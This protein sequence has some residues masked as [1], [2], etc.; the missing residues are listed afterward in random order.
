[1][2]NKFLSMTSFF[3]LSLA[4]NAGATETGPSF[5]GAE[6]KP[7]G[8][9]NESI[10]QLQIRFPSGV[11]KKAATSPFTVK[12]NP[13]AEGF[14]SWADNETLWTYNFKAKDRSSSNLLAGGTKCSIQQI[15]EV[16]TSDQKVWKKGALNY[17]VTVMGPKVVAVHVAHGF[18]QTLR[19]KEPLMLLVFNGPVDKQSLYGNGSS[20]LSYTSSN[21][22]TEKLS[23]LPVPQDQLEKLFGEFKNQRYFDPEFKDSNWALATVKQNLIPGAQMKL[24]VQNQVSGAN[25]DVKMTEK[26]TQDFSVRSQFQAEIL[27]S[28]QSAKSGTCMPNSAIGVNLNGRVKWTD[29]RKAYIEYIPYQSKDRKTVQSFAEMSGNQEIG[30][31]DSIVDFLA[32]YFPYL[33]KYSDTVVDS[34]TFNVKI[35]P[36]T[37]AKVVLP[38][39]LIDIDGRRLA[40]ALTTFHIKIGSMEEWINTPNSLAIYERNTPQLAIPVGIV[41]LHQK[42]SIRKSGADSNEWI[43]VQD[44]PTMV[45]LI[46]SYEMVSTYRQT[47]DYVSPLEELK[48]ANNSQTQVMKGTKNRPEVLQFPLAKK[49]KAPQ[50]GLYALEISSP[51]LEQENSNEEYGNYL[52]PSHVLAQVTDLSVHMKKGSKQTLLWITRL[53]NAA[54]VAHADISIY[55]CLGE[56]VHTATTDTQGLVTVTNQE[57]AKDCH[58]QQNEYTSYSQK[59]EFFVHAKQGEDSLLAHSSWV[60]PDSYALGAPGVEWFYSKLEEDANYYHSIIGVNLVKPGQEVPVQL[61]AKR[62]EARGFSTVAPAELPTTARVSF[63]YDDET[64]FDFPLQ[65]NNGKAEF[66]WKVPSDNS[67]KLG[68][69]SIMLVD[70]NKDQR[71]ISTGGSIEVAEFKIPLMTGL[72]SLPNENLVQPNAIPVNAVIRYANGVGAKKLAADI[73]YYFEPTTIESKDFPGYTFGNGALQLLDDGSRPENSKLPNSD[74]P[75]T[76]TDLSTGTDGTL[77]LDIAKQAALEQGTIAEALKATDRPQKM[78]VRV[79][80]QDQMG[81]FQTLSRS[82]DIYNSNLYLGTKLRAGSREEARLL[83]AAINAEKKNMTNL[84]DINLKIERIETRVIG[85]ELYGGIIKNTLERQ[86]KPVRWTN[87]CRLENNVVNCSIGALK[88]GNYAFQVSSK[89]TQQIAHL[90]FKVD[91]S[92][93]VFGPREYYQ[94][95]DEQESKT[96][97]L[98]LNKE[99]YRNGEKAIVSFPPPFKSCQ[100]LVTLERNDVMQGF[101][102]ADGCSKGRVEIPVDSSLAPNAFVSVYAVAGRVDT[103]GVKVG[104]QDL[105]R[106]TYRLGFANIKVDWQ[107]F[108]SQVKVTLNKDT[109][110]PK[111]MVDVQAS[112][113]A[114]TGALTEGTVT[115][116]VLEEKILELKENNTYQILDALMQLR[117]HNVATVTSLERIETIASSPNPDRAEGGR[118]G[119]D[120]GGDGGNNAEFKRKLFDALVA[121]KTNVP[122]VNGVAKFSFKTN[123]S[124]TRFKVIA[125]AMDANNKFGTG[126]AGY[127]SAQDVQSY[128]NIP[129]VAYSGDE[130]PLKVTVQNNSSNDANYRA[131]ITITMKDSHGNIIGTK[132]LQKTA[133]IGASSS[134]AIDAGSFEINEDAAKIEYTIRIYDENGKLVDVLEPEAQ[135]VLPTVPLSIQRSYLVQMEQESWQKKVVKPEGALKDKGELQIVVS[136]S[137]VTGALEQIKAKIKQ[138]PFADFFIEARL[139]KALLLGSEKNVGD[140]KTV[141][142]VMMGSVDPN[143]F[144]KYFPG[145]TKGDAYLTAQLINALE[146]RPWA[147]AQMPKALNS[148]LNQAVNLVLSKKADPNYVGKTPMDWARLQMLMVRSALVLGNKDLEALAKVVAQQIHATAVKDEKPFGKA[149][150]EWSTV[151]LVNLWLTQVKTAPETALQSE[152]Y[153]LLTQPSRLVYAGNGAQF[154]GTPSFFIRYTDEIIETAQ[155]L[156]GHASVNG[157]KDLARA[158][159]IGLVNANIK[160]CWYNDAT[161][162]NLALG[163]EAFAN[164]YEMATVSG[165]GQIAVSQSNDR[166]EINW[167][168]TNKSTLKTAWKENESV[169]DVQHRGQGLPWVGVQALAAVPLNAPLAQGVSVEKTLRNLNRE[170]GY[171]AGDVIEVEL[172][173]NAAARLSH[174]ALRDPIPAGSNILSEAYGDY[175]SG[176]KRYSGYWLYFSSIPAG[177]SKVKYQFQLNNPGTF[178]MAP[179]RV[180]GIY[181]PSVFA[182]IPNTALTVK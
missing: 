128:S 6:P 34:I 2:K 58:P 166:T 86:L 141:F 59:D 102:T 89:S 161:L 43:P 169:I 113:Q 37:Q 181:M 103:G 92:G 19:E 112:V 51:S 35:E 126:E 84:A 153:K 139:Y 50:N 97:P 182:E 108:R 163:L 20:Y 136:N 105:G 125:V 98:A 179:T 65:W 10:S 124:L 82:K 57:W 106:P 109:F 132:T 11:L 72:I 12:C 94:F 107:Q 29:L 69:Y 155:F 87:D 133:K 68:G 159:A 44:V 118:K 54:P 138:D 114:E 32:Q 48:I 158:I 71:L 162:M 74:R 119:G 101:I 42:I 60:S 40:N 135:T 180:E 172:T 25:A 144:I 23:L 41:N 22:P 177:V 90:L 53:S 1:M 175:S 52:N 79:R 9:V 93:R 120:E 111:Q 152:I 14:A 117:N 73:S 88:A 142:E 121:F 131:E 7:I 171:Q 157:S 49:D 55:N 143:G 174:L 85:E 134:S 61:I 3:C 167:S 151:D 160:G 110:Q 47:K 148:K 145:A 83:V 115:F 147:L 130:Y 122:V 80:Y 30:L 99:T 91:D 156:L 100:A 39:N 27:C 173:L 5:N 16:T 13:E 4:L 33:A 18:Q 96:L 81:E 21:A 129:A 15:D 46:R 168:E 170:N 45:R 62:P 176:Q 66:T 154:N 64:Y 104:E 123:D 17:E 140:L 78:V 127:L 56:K 36:E 178:K 164:R 165:T 24:T 26:Y 149:L 31:W 77:T 146:G 8:V 28:N 75:A 70:Q 67:A 137:L 95:G 116:I 38:K 63:D 76:V 150:N